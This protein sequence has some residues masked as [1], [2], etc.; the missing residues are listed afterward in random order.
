LKRQARKAP[1]SPAVTKV[2][3]L[4]P[5]DLFI[6][7]NGKECTNDAKRV[8]NGSLNPGLMFSW[9]EGPRNEMKVMKAHESIAT[10]PLP[11]QP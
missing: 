8:R 11:V 1:S 9:G 2:P 7:R 4:E 10:D 6:K 3:Q 5:L